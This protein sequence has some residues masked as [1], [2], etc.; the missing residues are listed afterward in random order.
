MAGVQLLCLC[1]GRGEEEERRMDDVA[2]D[3]VFQ[4]VFFFL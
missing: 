3:D 2:M 4:D 1:F